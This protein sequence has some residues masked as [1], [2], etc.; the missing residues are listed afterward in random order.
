[1]SKN[2]KK[3]LCCLLIVAT[4]LFILLLSFRDRSS[5]PFLEYLVTRDEFENLMKDRSEVEG[6][7]DSISMNDQ[8]L[9]YDSEED[10][11]LYSISDD[12]KNTQ[13]P[14]VKINSLNRNLKIAICEQKIT[15]E[16]VARN[17]SID[18]LVYDENRYQKSQIKC[19]T[20]PVMSIDTDEEIPYTRDE[21]GMHMKL[22]D[23]GQDDGNRLLVSE[24]LIHRRGKS[25]FNNP[26]GSYKLSLTRK[27]SV[28]SKHSNSLSLLGMPSDDDW[29]L[30][31]MYADTERIRDVFCTNL[32]TKTFATDNADGVNLGSEYRYVEVFINGRYSGVY[33]LGYKLHNRQLEISDSSNERVLYFK[34]DQ[35][36]NEPF[37]I[38]REGN[39]AHFS[40]ESGQ[41]SESFAT[42]RD[43]LIKAYENR[44]NKDELYSMIDLDNLVDF[45]LYINFIQGVD[46][47]TC[48]QYMLLDNID[49]KFRLMYAPWDMDYSFGRNVSQESDSGEAYALSPQEMYLINFGIIGNVIKCDQDAFTDKLREK[50][51]AIRENTWSD[52]AID[53]LIGSYEEKLFPSG[54]YLRE[55]DRW[56][57]TDWGEQSDGLSIFKEYV[58][59]RLSAMDSFVENPDYQFADNEEYLSFGMAEAYLA[60][61]E[62]FK[63]PESI[64]LL[65]INDPRMLDYQYYL[66]SM[67]KLGIP[68]ELTKVDGSLRDQ[69]CAFGDSVYYWSI[70]EDTDVIALIGD[71]EPLS[72][73]DF[74]SG[75]VAIPLD[76]GNLTFR[77]D[78]DGTENLLL[79]GDVIYSESDTPTDF[80]L[81]VIVISPDTV[82]VKNVSVW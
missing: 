5:D 58:H 67:D 56:K 61:E 13:N 82:T 20:L 50:Y 3:I 16:V 62:M 53:E 55:R 29:V 64:R 46:S 23:N 8:E 49:G 57:N 19:T 51:R 44:D 4:L 2:R 28:S 14:L 54:A 17:E 41:G 26:K 18:F 68:D 10:F 79:N 33:A 45:F 11:F 9:F 34:Y 7:F 39:V 27:S 12:L 24:G 22:Y 40:I 42:F 76:A 77:T 38:D 43:F 21:I 75:D 52:D 80:L 1:M 74:F 66:D 36:P 63:Y 32:W 73:S 15:S 25:S 6:L 60:S 59:K 37:Y 72:Y 81:R 35:A 78:N 31:S 65:Q 71:S 48:N 69:L 47:T 70:P 30:N